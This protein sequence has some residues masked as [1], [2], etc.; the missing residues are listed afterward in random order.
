M[1]NQPYDLIFISTILNEGINPL[2]FTL[3]EYTPHVLEEFNADMPV[4]Q[5]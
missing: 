3:L 1:K 2:C 5:T 4:S